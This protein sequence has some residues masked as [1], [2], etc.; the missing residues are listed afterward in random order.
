MKKYLFLLAT[1]AIFAACSSNDDPVLENQEKESDVLIGFGSTYVSKTTK[2]EITTDWFKTNGNSF[3]VYGF[4]YSE[5]DTNSVQL[6]KNEKVTY[7]DD[8]WTNPTKRYWDKSVVSDY[9]FYAYAPYAD[10]TV[11]SFTR[12]GAN[13]GDACGFTYKL[14]KDVVTPADSANAVDLV[15][16]RVINTDYNQ[17]YFPGTSDASDGH[18]TFIFHHALSKL[19]FEVK[20]DEELDDM[21]IVITD[22][23]VAFPTVDPE[24]GEII[25]T[26]GDKDEDGGSITYTDLI[27][28]DKN[29][30]KDPLL[31][32]GD[33]EVTGTKTPVDGVPEYI[34]TPSEDGETHTIEISVTYEITYPDGT[35]ET[36][37]A[38]GEIIIDF[39]EDGH[40]T[41]IINIKPALIEFDVEKVAEWK[42]QNNTPNF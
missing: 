25:W 35:T 27:E 9:H 23:D 38:T 42:D 41:V 5:T 1:A 21:D 2:A 40:Y 20:K 31:D 28:P 10:S 30:P 17:C 7:N 37:T 24:T 15:V 12:T 3:G 18:V 22:L 19:T 6:Y 33:Q 29:T 8:D 4:K 34:I 14:G 11:V 32:G 36:Q 16:A 26:Q 39:D 13:A